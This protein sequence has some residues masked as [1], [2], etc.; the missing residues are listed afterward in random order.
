[1]HVPYPSSA[2]S[3][4]FQQVRIICDFIGL[5][6]VLFSGFAV[7]CAKRA[8]EE[9]EPL[10]Y[11]LVRHVLMGMQETGEKIA[12]LGRLNDLAW[13]LDHARRQGRVDEKVVKEIGKAVSALIQQQA[14]QLEITYQDQYSAALATRR[15]FQPAYVPT[16]RIVT[17]EGTNH[18]PLLDMN[19]ISLLS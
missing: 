2:L 11:C 18:I 12:G 4:L 1:M 15:K 9:D 5:S 7:Y 3:L 10:W 13:Q 17:D 14:N 19:H 16:T 6:E 8:Q